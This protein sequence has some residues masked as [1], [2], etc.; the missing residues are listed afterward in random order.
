MRPLSG[1]DSWPTSVATGT[2]MWR[3]DWG[4]LLSWLLWVKGPL[5]P[6]ELPPWGADWIDH[7]ALLFHEHLF[8]LKPALLLIPALGISAVILLRSLWGRTPG[9][10][11]LG[12]RLIDGEGENAGPLRSLAHGL[13]SFLGLS[14]LLGGYAWAIVDLRRQGLAEYLSGTC[15]ILNPDCDDPSRR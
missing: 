3:I 10:W 4:V 14:L 11:L 1:G 6:E 2:G 12:L 7:L 9:E 15:L 5:R 13:G 8:R